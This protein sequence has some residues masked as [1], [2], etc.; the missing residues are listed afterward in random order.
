MRKLQTKKLY[1]NNI[2]NK[3]NLIFN[4]REVA[5]LCVEMYYNK[6]QLKSSFQ[7]SKIVYNINIVFTFVCFI[8]IGI[9]NIILQNSIIHLHKISPA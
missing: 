1:K 2:S 8:W 3:D 7:I 4:A 6:K 5:K 9:F